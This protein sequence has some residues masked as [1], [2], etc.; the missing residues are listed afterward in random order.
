M[1]VVAE[2]Q[3][4]VREPGRHGVQVRRHR[5]DAV[6]VGEPGGRQVRDDDGVRA[7]DPGRGHDGARLL[8]GRGGVHAAHRQARRRQVSGQ[9][10]RIAE[11]VERFHGH[12]TERGDPVQDALPVRRQLFADGVELQGRGVAGGRVAGGRAAGRGAGSPGA[13]RPGAGSLGWLVVTWLRLRC[14]GIS[15]FRNDRFRKLFATRFRLD[16]A[17]RPVNSRAAWSAP[18]RWRGRRIVPPRYAGRAQVSKITMHRS[19]R[20]P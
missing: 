2:P 4:L 3:A 15:V 9:P 5:P 10:G 19:R 17:A 8:A 20:G 6:E 13:G 7:E 18:A 16:S 1:V 12:V 11:D 14:V